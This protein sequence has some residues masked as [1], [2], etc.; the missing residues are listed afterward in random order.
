MSDDLLAAA[1]EV[2]TAWKNRPIGHVASTFEIAAE[3]LARDYIARHAAGDVAPPDL[4]AIAIRHAAATPGP[5]RSA[6][7][8]PPTGDRYAP[9]VYS[10]AESTE[11][12]V[13][14]VVVLAYYDGDMVGCTKEN[15]AFIAAAWED[16]RSLLKEVR[17][18]AMRGQRPGAAGTGDVRRN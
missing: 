10:V 3:W 4:D 16:V 2:C 13:R 9:T 8:D 7:D 18:P 6:W 12:C 17:L 5:W 15:A 1:N 11:T 14:G